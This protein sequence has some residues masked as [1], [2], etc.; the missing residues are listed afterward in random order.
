MADFPD[1]PTFKELGYPE[2]TTTTWFSLSG[3]A[4]LPAE[5]AQKVNREIANT[6]AKPEMRARMQHEGMVTQAL[7][8]EEFK[9]LVERETKF[10][11]PVIE[12]VGLIEK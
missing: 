1:V 4:G 2:F 12:K 8:P 10:W 3:P 11:R 7:T 5:I 9:A 6:M